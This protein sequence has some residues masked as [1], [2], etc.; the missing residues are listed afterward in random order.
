MAQRDPVP[1]LLLAPGGEI[2]ALVN[3]RLA[4]TI[5][6]ILSRLDFGTLAAGVADVAR[7]LTRLK[8]SFQP[9]L[10]NLTQQLQTYAETSGSRPS[11]AN[12]F[13]SRLYGTF[14]T[15]YVLTDMGLPLIVKEPSQSRKLLELTLFQVVK[16]RPSEQDSIRAISEHS[17]G[18]YSEECGWQMRFLPLP[19]EWIQVAATVFATSPGELF[20]LL[21]EANQERSLQQIMEYL[22]N[23]R[24][25]VRPFLRPHICSVW[26]F[27]A[28]QSLC[29]SRKS[30]VN[31]GSQYVLQ[32]LLSLRAPAIA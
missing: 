30:R 23:L 28:V 18:H 32:R 9:E 27:L 4:R 6:G 26:S 24:P 16:Q 8:G 3:A 29:R 7:H 12:S 13:P 1:R 11:G 31:R 22:R 5:F 21:S 10:D 20:M 2:Q 15:F 19:P 17:M 25:Q 14:G